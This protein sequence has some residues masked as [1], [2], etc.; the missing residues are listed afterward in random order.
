MD[1]HAVAASI[2]CLV[3][4]VASHSKSDPHRGHYHLPDMLQPVAIDV[5][6]Q[7]TDVDFLDK[8]RH[9]TRTIMTDNG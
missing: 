1:S 4:H 6:Q 5:P 2:L 8:T 7:L 9:I 3:G